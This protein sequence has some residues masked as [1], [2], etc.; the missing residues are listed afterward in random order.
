MRVVSHEGHALAE[1][2]IG[3]HGV[4]TYR[5][6]IS[7]GLEALSEEMRLR[8]PDG[9]GHRIPPPDHRS[10]GGGRVALNVASAAVGRSG[11]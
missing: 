7:F 11:M 6:G 8:R 9:L 10:G 1:A 5:G 3:G 2:V 4:C